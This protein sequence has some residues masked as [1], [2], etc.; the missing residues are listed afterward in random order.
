[1]AAKLHSGSRHRALRKILLALPVLAGAGYLWLC[2]WFWVHQREFQYTPGGTIATPATAG[3]PEFS[4]VEIATGDGERIIGWW[5]PPPGTG[6]GVVLYLHGTPG[7]LPDYCPYRLPDLETAGLGALAIDYRGYGGSTGIPTETGIRLDALAAFDFIRREAP[8]S[9]IAVYGESFG[10]GPA[11][12]LATRRPVAGLLLNAPFASVLRLFKRSAPPILPYRWLLSDQYDSERLIRRVTAPV[13]ILH[14]TADANIPIA[15][16]R[17][18][19]QAAGRSKTMIEV[20]GAG[21]TEAMQGAAKARA[22]E[23]LLAW[24]RGDPGRR[25]Q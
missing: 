6:D 13:M 1:M 24:T 5:K 3:L 4:T 18:L 7:T 16:A 11:V 19:Y 14:G 21:H 20:E 2:A 17:R 25:A 23:A 9:K 15:E 12:A 22:I 8:Q 10:S